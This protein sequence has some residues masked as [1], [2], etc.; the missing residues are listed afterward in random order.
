MEDLRGGHRIRA[1]ALEGRGEDGRWLAL[2][3]GISVGH[4]KIDVFPAAIVD[5]LRLRI[6]K[7]VGMPVIRELAAFYADGIKVG[8]GSHAHR[9]DPAISCGR[10]D[11]GAEAVKLNL[12]PHIRIPA[13]YQVSLPPSVKVVS[14]KLWFN[15]SEL[16][17]A[18]CKIEGACVIIRQTQ[19][20][21]NQTQTDLELSFAPNATAGEATIRMISEH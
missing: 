9:K 11:Q 2:A 3:E 15:G 12:T 17:P 20:V 8:K 19:Q 5:R 14:A 1:Y 16:P 7:N 18:D 4:K 6:T 21:T 13:T 10:W